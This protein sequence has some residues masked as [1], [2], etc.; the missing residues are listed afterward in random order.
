MHYAGAVSSKEV[1]DRV[2]RADAFVLTSAN[3]PWGNVLVSALSLGVPVVVAESAALSGLI[4]RYGAGLVVP[5]GDAQALRTALET[6]F[7]DDDYYTRCSE[8]ALALV[9]ENMGS[10]AQTKLLH[11]IYT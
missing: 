3:E 4:R 7:G 9:R 11:R 10:D 5:D 2:D 6:L 1:L 8:A